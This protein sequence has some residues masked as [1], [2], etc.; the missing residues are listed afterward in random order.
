MNPTVVFAAVMLAASGAVLGQVP[1]ATPAG[2]VPTNSGVAERQSNE[3]VAEPL[4]TGELHVTE[5]QRQIEAAHQYV[6]KRDDA[7]AMT[8]LRDVLRKEPSNRDA[9]LELALVLGYRLEYEKSNRLYRELIGADP[10]DE[11]ASLGLIRNLLREHKTAEVHAELRRAL[12][13]HPNS[14]LLQEYND[15][16]VSPAKAPVERN[17]RRLNISVQVSESFSADKAGNHSLQ[18]AQEMEYQINRFVGNRLRST[19]LLLW[20]GTGPKANV[21][22]PADEL[23]FRLTRF[24]AVWAEGGVIRF[25]DQTTKTSFGADVQLNPYSKL[26]LLGGFSRIPVS[27]TFDSTQFDLRA[28]GWHAGLNWHPRFLRVRGSLSRENYSDGNRRER[29]RGEIVHWSGGSNF[30][31]G[32]G[33][34]F[35]HEHFL[36]D[37]NHSYFSPD[38]YRRHLAEAGFRFRIGKTFRAEYLGRGGVESIS[39]GSWTPAGDLLLRNRISL[40]QWRLGID[41]SRMQL[42]QSTGAFHA[43]WANCTLG[44]EF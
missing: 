35:S 10:D 36:A 1:A 2:G 17:E 23:Q 38:E 21:L 7:R 13:L 9:K 3:H 14:I 29:E 27:P 26:D 40:R 43:N 33:Y 8:I 5:I 30:A 15:A 28:E 44:Y 12:A 34:E 24:L 31:L 25:P 37:L 16:A 32:G 19:S 42:A 22:N 11:A 18:S 41:Y 6:L 4:K 20:N 39:N